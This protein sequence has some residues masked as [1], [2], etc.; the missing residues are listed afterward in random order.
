MKT[1]SVDADL[2][3]TV[4][5]KTY[6]SVEHARQQIVNT[7]WEMNREVS[8][9]NVFEYLAMAGE[10]NRRWP[11]LK[12]EQREVIPT[13]EYRTRKQPHPLEAKVG[14]TPA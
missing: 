10:F 14:A 7:L 12:I 13:A 1:V 11:H 3:V 9:P 2:S 4:G 6:K 5:S 8:H